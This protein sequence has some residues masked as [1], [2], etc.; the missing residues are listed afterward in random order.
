MDRTLAATG[1]LIRQLVPV[2]TVTMLELIMRI[3]AEV[4]VARLLKDGEKYIVNPE[5]LLM[6]LKNYLQTN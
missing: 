5:V 6:L 1:L 3:N 4:T 2:I